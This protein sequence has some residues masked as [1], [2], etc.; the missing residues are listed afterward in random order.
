MIHQPTAAP[1]FRQPS[2]TQPVSYFVHHPSCPR[3]GYD[4][5]GAIAAWERF[6]PPSCPLD[7]TCTECGL[8]FA[9]R[10]LL[11]PVYALQLNMFEHAQ[12]R[13]IASFLYTWWKALRP[14]ALWSWIRM[15][16]P[17][18]RGPTARFAV[19]GLLLTHSI[20]IAFSVAIT[21]AMVRTV[22]LIPRTMYMV[23]SVKQSAIRAA[24][25]FG[26]DWVYGSPHSSISRAIAP[27]ELVALLAVMLV[28]LTFALLPVT[29]RKA[30][31]R[32]AHLGRI[33]SYSLVWLPIPFAA[34]WLIHQGMIVI[35]FVE[36]SQGKRPFW[37]SNAMD[38][39]R[40]VDGWI[41]LA[42]VAVWTATWWSFAAGRYLRLPNAAAIGLMMTALANL[43]VTLALLIFPGGAW[44]T[45]NF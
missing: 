18:R 4:Q 12:M 26:V 45:W 35:D 19:L 13:R 34:T 30:R 10:D 40:D 14:W 16:H 25:P 43:L 27:L 6:A 3:C 1:Q 23:G 8:E 31:V 33:W 36:R 11:N 38:R 22:G 2:P 44:F 29:L 24:N 41:T 32:R 21:F 28:P 39:I 7:G 42:A 15:E 37:L 17:I 5:S 9:W 20:V